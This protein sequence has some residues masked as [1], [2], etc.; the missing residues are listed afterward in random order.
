MA[1]SAE[2]GQRWVTLH[3]GGVLGK[4]LVVGGVVDGP[5]WILSGQLQGTR[6]TNNA[7]ADTI[8]APP[9]RLV[10]KESGLGIG[11]GDG[12]TPEGSAD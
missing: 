3:R 1:V 4:V 10:D 11:T 2:A 6:L 9:G 12:S 7:A 8:T 5:I